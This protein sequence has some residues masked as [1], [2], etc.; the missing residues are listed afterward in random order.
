ESRCYGYTLD[1]HLMSRDAIVVHEMFNGG[2]LSLHMRCS[3]EESRC[4]RY[5]LDV[6]RM[7]RD[8]I[9]VHVLPNGNPTPRWPVG[10]THLTYA[11]G[12]KFPDSF[13]PPVVSAFD[14]WASGSGYFTFSRVADIATS[15]LKISFEKMNHGHREEF[16]GPNGVLAH[17]FSP[18][19][20][21]LHFDEDENWSLGPGSVP[22]TYDFKTVT[23][24]EIGHLLGLHHSTDPNAVMFPTIR[25]GTVKDKLASD[26]IQGIKVLYG[27]IITVHAFVNTC[28]GEKKTANKPSQTSRGIPVGLKI[29]FK[30]QKEYIPVFKKPTGSSSGNKKKGVG[31][32]IEVSNSNPFEVLNSVDDDVEFGTNANLENNE[33]TTSGSSFMNVDNSNTELSGDYESEDEVESVDNY[34]ARS[35]ASERVGFG[36]QSLLEQWWDSYGNGDYD[37]DPYDDDMNEGQDLPQKLEAICDN[38]D[39]RVQDVSN[40]PLWLKLH[41]VSL[42]VFSEDGFSAIATKHD[43]SL[44]L[45]SYTSNMCIQS[46]GRS[47]Y[48]KVFIEIRVDVKLKDTIVVAMSKLVGEGFYTCIIRVEYEWKPPK[49]TCCKIF[50]H[51]QDEC[52]KNIGSGMVENLRNHSHAPRGV[53]LVRSTTP[54]V[55]KIDKVKRLII[56]GKVAF[57]D[58]EGKPLEKVD[59]A[60]DHDSDDEVELVDNKMT[61]FLASKKVGYGTNSLLEQLKKTY[62]NADYDYDPYMMISLSV[63]DEP[64]VKKKQ[65][66][67]VDKSIPNVEKQALNFM[68]LFTPGGNGVDIVVPLESIRAISESEDGL[69]DIA[70]KIG[71]LLM[72]DSYTSNM[73]ACCKVFGHIQEE[74]PKNPGLGVAKNLKKPSQAPRGVPVGSKVGFKLVKVYIPVSKKTTTSTSH[75]KHKVVELTKE[76]SNSNPFDVLNS[77]DNDVKFGTNG[78]TSKLVSNGANSSVSSFW[79]VQI[80]R[81]STTLIVDKIEKLEKLIIDGKVTLVNDG[82]PLKK[83]DYPG[84]H[85]CEDEVESV[86]NDMTRSMASERVSCGTKSLLEQLRDTYENDDYDEDPYDDDMYEG[87]DFP[88]KIQDICDNLD[89]RVRDSFVPLVVSAFDEW[90][91]GSGY[92]TFSRVADIGTSDLKISFQK[93]EHC[94]RVADFDGPLAWRFMK[95]DIYLGCIHS[96]YHDAVIVG[97]FSLFGTVKN[98]LTS[99][100]YPRNLKIFMAL[101]FDDEA[102]NH[103]DASNTGAAP[104]QQQHDIPQT[105][106]ISNIKLPILKKEEYDIWAMEMEHYLEYIDN[107]VWNVIQN[108]N[109]KKRISTGKDEV[110]RILPLV[111]AAEIQAVE[112]ERKAKNILLMAILKEHMRRF[113]GMDDAKEIWEAIKTRFGGNANSKKTQKA[114][115]KQQFEAF[116][117]SSSEGLEKGYDRFQQLLSQLEAHGAK[118]STEDANHKFL[119]SLPPT[120]SNLA[121]TMRTKPDVDTLSIDDVKSSTNKVKSGF[122]SA[123][124]DWDLLHEDLEQIDDLDIKETNHALMAISSSSEVSLCSKTCID[125]YNTL[126]TLFDKKKLECFNCHN[127]GHFARECTAK[128][129]HDGKKKRDSFYQHQEA[130]KQEKN[131]MGLLTI[132]DGIVNWGEHH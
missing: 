46:W 109:S 117:I 1:V 97:I 42:M 112:K 86:D 28:A 4:Y 24:H 121:M 96:I 12:S 71:T 18:T 77:V 30:P 87:R 11:F 38:L 19:D 91:S 114:V 31:L 29:G 69:S 48:T 35:M 64:V 8:A 55:E 79:N 88:D 110:I 52:L 132:D 68:T 102:S 101:N 131:Q 27:L 100:E 62:E 20:G 116:T 54:I 23:V 85:D 103:E 6:Q 14:E 105:T 127:T 40:V 49:C 26:D 50:G 125:S 123:Y 119:R 25:S 17:A 94:G 95:L 108:G 74:C 82:K 124:K 37:V 107:D 83:V 60:S 5:T 67:L 51:A 33:A 106:A 113:H 126:K 92:F 73:C 84:D 70:M 80:S 75:N 7:S 89:I 44:M 39:M 111:T 3:T 90:A 129:T 9:V 81:T 58:D 78:G 2:M 99:D 13:V 56:N 98:K 10:K 41:G 45:N 93:N 47:S 22:N 15:D 36:T 130:G 57:V 122:T 72:L 104:K 53:R 59:S 76:V 32:T 65:S 118:V 66:S 43:T 115:F 128:G 61:S 34:M 21:R 16:D 63:N 120:W